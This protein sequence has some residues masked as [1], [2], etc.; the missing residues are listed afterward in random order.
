MFAGRSLSDLQLSGPPVN[1]ATLLP[2][3]RRCHHLALAHTA[4]IGS[5]QNDSRVGPMDGLHQDIAYGDHFK[6]F[7]GFAIKKLCATY[8]TLAREH[9][10]RTLAHDVQFFRGDVLSFDMSRCS[11]MECMLS[12]L[13][14]NN[15]L[16]VLPAQDWGA[17]LFSIATNVVR[18]NK[19]SAF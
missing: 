8:L 15:L 11:S 3:D 1:L 7:R 13:W 14:S 19:P 18:K 17:K 16:V 5:P 4:G 9:H 10:C 12:S 6:S 2:C